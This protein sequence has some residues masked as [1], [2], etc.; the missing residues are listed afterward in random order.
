MMSLPS[1]CAAAAFGLVSAVLPGD[2]EA[3]KTQN[4]S[5][6][7]RS[8]FIFASCRR[9]SAAV[10]RVVQVSQGCQ[11]SFCNLRNLYNLEIR[12]LLRC[13]RQNSRW[14]SARV[15]GI[16]YGDILVGG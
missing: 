9:L 10:G 3:I 1:F 8:E 2:T 4:T 15:S 7:S 12:T 16:L 11:I 13:S 6:P 5:I 14:H